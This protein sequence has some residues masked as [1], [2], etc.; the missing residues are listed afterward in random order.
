MLE[1]K[2]G[3][4]EEG[5][6]LDAGKPRMELVPPELMTGV[7]EILTFGAEK[8]AE[9]NWELGIKW[10]RVYGAL[11][12]HMWSWWNPLEAD[13]DPETGKSHLWH[14]G[15]C[16]SFLIAYEVRGVGEDD[17]PV[18]KGE[19]PKGT[20]TEYSFGENDLQGRRPNG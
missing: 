4:R 5:V 18:R 17:R 19:E 20:G 2:I 6:K 12:R 13:T 10:G 8:Y 7:A 14:A 1:D 16:L 15:C 9:R 11:M 3:W